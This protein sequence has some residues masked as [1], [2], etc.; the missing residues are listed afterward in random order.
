MDGIICS[1]PEG[2]MCQCQCMDMH[3]AKHELKEHLE[4]PFTHVLSRA[5]QLQ[6]SPEDLNKSLCQKIDSIRKIQAEIQEASARII[7]TITRNTFNTIRNLDQLASTYKKIFFDPPQVIDPKLKQTEVV[8]TFK[9]Q[10]SLIDA[11]KLH[12]EQKSV[13][14][15][16]TIEQ[17]VKN[18][19]SKIAKI[20]EKYCDAFVC[21]V[22]SGDESFAITGGLSGNIRVWDLNNFAQ[23]L[24]LRGHKDQVISI[25]LGS[26]DKV[27]LSGSSD[28]T[29]RLWS[30]EKKKLEHTFK[31]HRDGINSV[32][33]SKNNKLGYSGSL[34]GSLKIWN[35]DKK[36][37]E[38]SLSLFIFIYG[39]ILIKEE[40]IVV[41]VGA[42]ISFVDQKTKKIN[43]LEDQRKIPI[44]C[45]S[46]TKCEKKFASGYK[47]G[48]IKIWDSIS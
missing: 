18:A 2:F 36:E 29:V 10:N 45:I 46:F 14:Q 13:A 20:Y 15:N 28:C 19:K 8:S 21:M 42:S 41:T 1:K 31:G 43:E 34:D 39:I 33:I 17:L 32:L 25:A 12:F 3:V 48:N 6:S 27:F 11:L 24:Y 7:Q 30:L 47:D 40:R 38:S 37:I 16:W 44:N 4:L 5:S 26:G 9:I 22:A 23:S 35:L